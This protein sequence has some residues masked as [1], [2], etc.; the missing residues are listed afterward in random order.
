MG[1]RP[2]RA[3]TDSQVSSTQSLALPRC[4]GRAASVRVTGQEPYSSPLAQLGPGW[5]PQSGHAKMLTTPSPRGSRP[6][7]GQL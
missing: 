5:I 4:A 1:S 7:R 6:G 2:H 3:P